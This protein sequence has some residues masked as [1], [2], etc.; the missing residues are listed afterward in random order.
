MSQQFL[1][2]LCFLVQR[3]WPRGKEGYKSLNLPR[4]E[5]WLVTAVCVCV[6]V[7]M[8]VCMYVCIYVCMYLCLC[9]YV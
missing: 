3:T 4:G 2:Q 5:K 9:V 7:C 1:S 6:C 8:Y